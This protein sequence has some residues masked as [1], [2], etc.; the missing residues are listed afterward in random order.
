M[1]V[2]RNTYSCWQGPRANL[3]SHGRLSLA[4]RQFVADVCA[5]TGVAAFESHLIA[6]EDPVG[7]RSS[8]IAFAVRIIHS[9]FVPRSAAS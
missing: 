4:R 1:L 7:A 5:K 2:E 8:F 9:V 6:S 3:S